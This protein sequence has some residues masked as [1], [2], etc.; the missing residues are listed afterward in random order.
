MTLAERLRELIDACFTGLW[1]QSHEHDDAMA[2]I[3]RLC[4][5]QSWRLATWD[6]SRGLCV[7]GT[8][9]STTAAAG[10]DPLAALR[11]LPAFATAEGTAVLVL[12]NFHR[13]LQSAE[14]I[15]TLARQLTAGK[16]SRTFVVI[17]SPVIQI[18]IELEKLFLVVEHE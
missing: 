7:A 2:E 3:A 13:F 10:Q 14:I 17:L 12:T 4:H 8:A 6:V 9:E 16:Q 15:Q 18:P 1:V 5:D 11:A